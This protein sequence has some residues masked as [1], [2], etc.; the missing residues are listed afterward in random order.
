[1]RL[2]FT[3]STS[4]SKKTERLL[5]FRTGTRIFLNTSWRRLFFEIPSIST[6]VTTISG[7]SYKQ[8][9]LLDSNGVAT[10]FTKTSDGI[11][12]GFITDVPTLSIPSGTWTFNAFASISDDLVSA[13]RFYYHIYKY[14]GTTL[15][16]IGTTSNILSS[17]S[18]NT[19]LDAKQRQKV[20]E[21]LNNIVFNKFSGQKSQIGY[22]KQ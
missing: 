8:F 3:R 12:A 2:A 16:S 15:T 17:L 13:P 1:M 6:A 7:L 21:T 19:S 14:N 5:Y 10:N 4:E 9:G 18:K 22:W 20:S 11:V